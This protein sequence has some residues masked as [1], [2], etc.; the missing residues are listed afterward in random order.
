MVS[1][2]LLRAVVIDDSELYQKVLCKLVNAHP[3]LLLVK[4]YK[5]AIAAAKGLKDG[6]VDLIFLDIEMPIINGFDFLDTLNHRPQ[7]ILISGKAEYAMRAF[8]Y[9]V[10]DYLQKPIA[11]ERFFTAVK[12][13]LGNRQQIND[14]GEGNGFLFVNSNL[15]KRKVVIDQIKWIEALGDYIRLVTVDESKILVL[16]TMKSFLERLPEDK[17]LRIHKSFVVNVDRVEK[18]CSTNVEISGKLIPMSRYKKE[19]LEKALLED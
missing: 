1:N 6:Q 7:V 16:S 17:F 13:A 12:K 2:K 19:R 15:Q 3:G 8:D 5:S 4:V 14:E 10:V 11:K 9:D 18:F